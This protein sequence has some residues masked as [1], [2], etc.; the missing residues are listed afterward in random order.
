LKLKL[1]IVEKGGKIM[2]QEIFS[3]IHPIMV[4]FPIVL[5]L[6]ATNYDLFLTI[7]KRR[8]SPKQGFL[9]WAAAFIF[10]WI[11]VGTGPGEDARGNTNLFKYHSTLADLTTVLAAVVVAFRLFFIFRRKELIKSLLAV[12]CLLSIVCA[13]AILSVGYFG[14]AMVYDQ[15]VGVK[16]HGKYVNPPHPGKFGNQGD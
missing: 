7:T 2:F 5:I 14:G 15:G 11:A 16:M 4:H 3:H 10:A 9:L 1:P 12:Y 8:I 6:L 13:V